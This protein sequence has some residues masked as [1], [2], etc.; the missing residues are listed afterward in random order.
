LQP[1]AIDLL[2]LRSLD[3]PE[4][5]LTP[6]RGLMAR[7]MRAD[8]SGRGAL[9]LAGAV[10]EAELPKHVKAG[11]EVRLIVREVSAERVTLSLSEELAVPPQPASVPLPGGGRVRVT[12][13]EQ[14]G[15]G[16]SDGGVETL[17]LRYDAPS[18]GPVDLRFELDR[19][20]LRV[21]VTL[22]AGRPLVQGQA[23]AQALLTALEQNVERAVTVKLLPRHEPFDLYA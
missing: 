2:L 4:L 3:A 1:L 12:E 19:A 21:A 7:V 14:A 13:R 10:I 22:S 5:R 9:S 6:G 16:A 23:G 8:G 20:S 18:L 17:S 15:G 11:Q